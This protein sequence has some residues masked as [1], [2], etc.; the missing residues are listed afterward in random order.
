[1]ECSKVNALPVSMTLVKPQYLH[2]ATIS[3][4]LKLIGA[5][6]FGHLISLTTANAYSS[7]KR[8]YPFFLC[9]VLI[10]ISENC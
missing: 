9:R 1:M 5:A 2:V 10:F 4:A 3:P 8:N 7:T 6:Q